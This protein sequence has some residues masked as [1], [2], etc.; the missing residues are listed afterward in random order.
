VPQIDWNKLNYLI[1]RKG[2]DSNGKSRL[3]L[4][5]TIAPHKAKAIQT[6]G[7]PWGERKHQWT[8]KKDAKLV[9]RASHSKTSRKKKRKKS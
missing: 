6:T 8:F 3:E 5:L 7:F 9:K 1:A 2:W 4:S